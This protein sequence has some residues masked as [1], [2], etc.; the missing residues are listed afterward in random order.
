[1]AAKSASQEAKEVAKELA[2]NFAAIDSP[3]ARDVY[4]ELVRKDMPEHF[5]AMIE[6]LAVMVNKEAAPGSATK[7]LTRRY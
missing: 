1:M 4:C 5:G 3:R 7:E 6:A 2:R